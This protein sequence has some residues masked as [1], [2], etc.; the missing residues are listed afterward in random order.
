V[1]RW[2]GWDEGWMDDGRGELACARALRCA[3][4][5]W[6]AGIVWAVKA[7]IRPP[8]ASDI[9]GTKIGYWRVNELESRG[10]HPHVRIAF[11]SERRPRTSF[12]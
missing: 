3:A 10:L 8:D 7:S 5:L 11:I 1:V 6:A 9:S 4:V 12:R 2:M